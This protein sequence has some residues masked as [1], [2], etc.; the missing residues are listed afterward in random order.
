V[1]DL[2]Y[3]ISSRF[4][5]A[6]RDSHTISTK[7]ELYNSNGELLKDDFNIVSGNVSVD[8]TSST[9]RRANITLSDPDNTLV[10][11]AGEIPELLHPLSNNYIKLYRGVNFGDIITPHERTT[12]LSAPGNE[13]SDNTLYWVGLGESDWVEG[14]TSS[15]VVPDPLQPE[16]SYSDSSNVSMIEVIQEPITIQENVLGKESDYLYLMVANSEGT[17]QSTWVTDNTVDLTDIDNVNVNCEFTIDRGRFYI[18]ASSSKTGS[19]ITYDAQLKEDYKFNQTT[20]VLDVSNLS[21]SY[22]IR[23]HVADDNVDNV[24]RS[25]AKI[26]SV[27]LDESPSFK[28]GLDSTSYI[29]YDRTPDVELV[30]LATLDI[31]DTVIDDTRDELKIQLRLFDF[32][33]KIE[34]ARLLENYRI[35]PGTNYRDAIHDIINDGVPDLQY[36]LPSVDF[37]TPN[38]VFGSSGDQGGGDRWKYAREMAQSI[39]YDLYLNRNGVVTLRPVIDVDTQPIVWRYDETDNAN[40]LFVTR[41]ISKEETYNVVQARGESTSNDEPVTAIAMDE[42]PLSSTY[43]GDPPGSSAYGMVPTFLNSKY[44][45]TENQAQQ[46]AEA[47]LKQV[48]GSTEKMRIMTIVNPAFEGNDL[49]RVIRGRSNLDCRFLIDKF[50]VPLEYNVSMNFTMREMRRRAIE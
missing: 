28:F 36:D 2:M 11:M 1:V 23:I 42:N 8:A 45:T 49:I 40:L 50:N 48:L 16:S 37:V 35:A 6:I 46:A 33:R 30:P 26:Y 14:D 43:V 32:S 29:Y 21:G 12:L 34:R 15:W 13:L 20:K 5:E 7:M 18:I 27:S 22:Y 3:N 31:F 38:L 19:V 10:P 25:E 24:A 17:S 39:G 44:I 47:R 9:R 4:R 41:E